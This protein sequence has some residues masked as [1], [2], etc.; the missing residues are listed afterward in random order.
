MNGW[1]FGVVRERWVM[2]QMP[3]DI[4]L[5]YGTRQPWMETN[6][7][8]RVNPESESI[9]RRDV[10]D[11]TRARTRWTSARLAPTDST[12][13]RTLS[14]MTT[15]CDSLALGRS[16]VHPFSTAASSPRCCRAATTNSGIGSTPVTF[17][18]NFRSATIASG[19]GPQPTT[20]KFRFGQMSTSSSSHSRIIW[21]RGVSSGRSASVP[22][23]PR[24]IERRGSD[25]R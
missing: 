5:L 16:S 2:V 23:K 12:C 13:S 1:P 11:A 24:T 17:R 15:S 9:R 10:C 19:R 22:G 14:S 3:E 20:R 8:L 25:S 7:E 4:R 21:I 18:P 6:I